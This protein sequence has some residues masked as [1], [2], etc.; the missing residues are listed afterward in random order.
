MDIVPLPMSPPNLDITDWWNSSKWE[1]ILMGPNN[2]PLGTA[3]ATTSEDERDSQK[4]KPHNL[5]KLNGTKPQVQREYRD[6][7]CQKL[8]LIY[9]LRAMNHISRGT[10]GVSRDT[11]GDTPVVSRDTLGVSRDTTGVSRDND[12]QTPHLLLLLSPLCSYL[13]TLCLLSL[14]L[15]MSPCLQLCLLSL[16]LLGRCYHCFF[17]LLHKQEFKNSRNWNAVILCIFSCLM[18]LCAEGAIRHR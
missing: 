1:N 3:K 2:E 4:S 18:P 5:P 14:K 11:T 13:Q 9:H 6:N 10:T 7:G 15:E 17:L 12:K 8:W 16:Q